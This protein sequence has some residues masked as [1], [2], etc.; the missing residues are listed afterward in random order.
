MWIPGE[1]WL[2]DPRRKDALSLAIVGIDAHNRSDTFAAIGDSGRKIVQKVSN[3]SS[4][5]HLEAI[6]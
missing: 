5:G 1:S 2:S 4:M 6:R 3:T